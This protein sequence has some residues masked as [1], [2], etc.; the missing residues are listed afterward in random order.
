MNYVE[1]K[2]RVFCVF[3]GALISPD[4]I[5]MVTYFYSKVIAVQMGACMHSFGDAEMLLYFIL[6]YCQ[7][8]FIL[9]ELH[10]L[11]HRT[12]SKDTHLNYLHFNLIGIFLAK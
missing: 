1:R 11:E 3:K 8:S 5:T 4:E 12:Q 9:L 6:I 7:V 2:V 10:L